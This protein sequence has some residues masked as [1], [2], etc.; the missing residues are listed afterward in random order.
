NRSSWRAWVTRVLA[1]VVLITGI[2][3]AAAQA[4]PKGKPG[5]TPPG[6]PPG[7]PFQALQKEID[8]LSTRVTTLEA[9]APQSGLMRVN[10]LD[11]LA[12]GSSR[13]GRAPS[14]RG[15]AA[16]GAAA[17]SDTLQ[18]GLP[19]PWGFS[20]SGARVCYVPGALGSS[21]TCVPLFQYA[22]TPATPPT[23]VV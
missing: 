7:R 17:G 8:A 16:A 12:R 22:A 23:A 2:T 4:D 11:F 14:G 10:P 18:A 20:V 21:L 13:L 6:V 3:V 1:G 5:I 19:W 15:L 9:L